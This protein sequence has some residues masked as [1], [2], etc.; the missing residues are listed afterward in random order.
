M[1]TIDTVKLLYIYMVWIRLRVSESSRVTYM[2]QTSGIFRS[3]LKVLF[4]KL[5]PSTPPW[6]SDLPFVSAWKPYHPAD[7]EKVSA[8]YMTSIHSNS[9]HLKKKQQKTNI[10]SFSLLLSFKTGINLT[11]DGGTMGKTEK[12]IFTFCERLFLKIN[13]TTCFVNVTHQVTYQRKKE[14]TLSEAMWMRMI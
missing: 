12:C 1:D 10:D 14:K 7:T 4:L 2:S 6:P 13:E 11:V 9:I 8:F 5:W 3:Y